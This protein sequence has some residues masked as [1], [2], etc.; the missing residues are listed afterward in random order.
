LEPALQEGQRRTES[1]ETFHFPGMLGWQNGRVK[2]TDLKSANPVGFRKFP[3][4]S[5]RPI[6][7]DYAICLVGY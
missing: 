1:L 4:S 7:Y 5:Y 6:D 2:L 3:M